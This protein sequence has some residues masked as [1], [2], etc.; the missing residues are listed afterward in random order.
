MEK[1]AIKDWKYYRIYDHRT[2][3]ARES[4]HHALN[5]KFNNKHNFRQFVNVIRNEVNQLHEEIEN[6]RNGQYLDKKK[7]YQNF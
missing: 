7:K 3:N 1:Y 5:S 4:Y 2:N 6:L